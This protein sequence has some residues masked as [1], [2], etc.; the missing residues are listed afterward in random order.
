[1][2]SQSIRS[3]TALAVIGLCLWPV[4]KGLSIIRFTLA[5]A[6][7]EDIRPWVAA[8][9]LAFDAREDAL[10]PIDD[11]SDDTTIRARLDEIGNILAVRPLSSEYWV[12]LAEARVDAHE[13]LAKVLEALEMSTVTG[14]N[15]EAMIT[16]RGLFGIWQ[17]ETLP[18]DEQRR[19]IADLAAV[20]PSD[21]KA[22]WLKTTLA[23]KPEAVRQD[24]RAALE[25]Q[26]FKADDFARIGL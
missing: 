3:L 1:M 8:S 25:A 18:A 2:R 23:E 26:G 6:A 21:P 20:R 13:P 14:P 22:A 11:A 17:W 15:E 12:Q 4:W 10:T 16:Q 19:A 9:G 5:D 24:I 7:S